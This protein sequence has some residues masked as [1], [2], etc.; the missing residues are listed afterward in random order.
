MIGEVQIDGENTEIED[1]KK[2]EP[3]FQYG[4]GALYL[5]NCEEIEI[6]TVEG[7]CLYHKTGIK[8]DAV[9]PLSLLEG[10]TPTL[11][12]VTLKNGKRQITKRQVILD[13]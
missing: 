10:T 5:S 3:D 9:V 4:N 1:R 11:I 7:K 8:G 12:L 2:D 13:K 6:H